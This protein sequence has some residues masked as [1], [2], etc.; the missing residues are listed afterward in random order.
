MRTTLL[1]ILLLASSIISQPSRDEP[2][3]AEP[4]REEP[5]RTPTTTYAPTH[6]PITACERGWA[7]LNSNIAFNISQLTHIRE[8]Q[9]C[10]N[11]SWPKQADC[12]ADSALVP[13]GKIYKDQC[14]NL[15]GRICEVEVELRVGIS[16]L[17]L[18]FDWCFPSPCEQAERDQKV[19][20]LSTIFCDGFGSTTCKVT[21]DCDTG[22]NGGTIIAVIVIV[23]LIIIIAI[24]A[25]FLWKKRRSHYDSVA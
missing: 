17:E 21:I 24:I 20:Q 16:D 2:T 10:A 19:A 3:R 5:T 18:D 4:T 6:I 12:E 7:E 15:N 11:V 25:I 14:K 1:F 23:V 8:I 9:N 22:S 13:S